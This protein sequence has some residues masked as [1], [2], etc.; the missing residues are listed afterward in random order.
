MPGGQVNKV[1]TIDPAAGSTTPRTQ[2]TFPNLAGVSGFRAMETP[3]GSSASDE[4]VR[5]VNGLRAAFEAEPL[6]DG[7]EHPAEEVVRQAFLAANEAH[8]LEWLWE[9]ALDTAHP[10]LAASVL[11][12]LGRLA[13]PGADSWR[14][15]LIRSALDIGDAEIRDAA[16]QASE[17]WG[18][19]AVRKVLEAHEEPLPWLRNY[20]RDV[21]E[22]LE[23]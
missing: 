20:I 1:T 13:R 14:T 19:D 15:D 3:T 7:M 23:E 21:V 9:L 2:P 12:C 17:A 22:D 6:E 5:V 8:V 11:R 18:G 4:K 10:N 16:V